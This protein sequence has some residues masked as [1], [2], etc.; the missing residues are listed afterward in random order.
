MVRAKTDPETQKYC[1]WIVRAYGTSENMAT[2]SADGKLEFAV[3]PKTQAADLAAFLLACD[4]ERK[5]A[6]DTGDIAV[7]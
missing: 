3:Q 2:T 5:I 4:F 1:L 7:R 6:G